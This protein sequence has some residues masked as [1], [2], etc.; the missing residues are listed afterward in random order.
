MAIQSIG[1]YDFPARDAIEN[2]GGVLV[3]YW[4]WLDHLMFCA[5]VAFPFPPDMRFGDVLEQVFPGVYGAHPDFTKI[6][7]AAA[8]WTLDGQTFTPDLDRSLAENGLGHK[9]VVK[10][11][12]PGLDGIKGSRT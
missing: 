3:T 7:W 1:D 6:D 10:F 2:F 11:E 4:N 5:P 8:R 12:T 9:S